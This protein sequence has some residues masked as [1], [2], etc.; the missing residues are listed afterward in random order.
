[1]VFLVFAAFLPLT[2]AA[3]EDQQ[4]ETPEPIGG[5]TFI[6]EV[7]F[8]VVNVDVFVR[9]KKGHPVTGLTVEDFR[10]FQDGDPRKVTNFA[11]FSEEVVAMRLA[12]APVEPTPGPTPGDHVDTDQD[13][14]ARAPEIKPVYI[15]LYIDNE[16]LRPFDRNRVLTQVRRF[17]REVMYPH[18]RVMVVSYQRSL[19]IIQPFTND[20][21][22]V[23]DAVK[24]VFKAVGG[25]TEYDNQRGR[26]LRDLGKLREKGAQRGGGNPTGQQLEM[27]ARIQTYADQIA[28]DLEFG[29][30]ALRQVTTS[31]SGL[32][33]R[34]F[35]VYVSSGLPMTPAK[36]L[37]NEFSQ[38]YEGASVLPMMMR[39]N[40]KRLYDNLT[41]T[42]NAQGVAFITI[43]ATG[44]GGTGYVSA[45]Y[46]TP[47]DPITATLYVAN[48]QETLGYMADRTGGR[49][50]LNAN[51][52]T[53][54]LEDFRN[55]LFTYYSLGYTIS[56]SGSDRVHRIEV[57]VPD[58]TEYQVSYRRSFVEKSLATRVQDTVV[59]GLMYEL[60]DNPMAIR[61]TT[62][63]AKP[64]T[65]SRWM[66]PLEVSVPLQSIALVQHGE[67]YVGQV[68]LFMAAR[69]D[70][71]KQSDLQ[72]REQEIR[73]PTDDID[74][75]RN[76]TIVI[77]M[78][79]LM[80]EGRYRLSIGVLDSFTRQ[81]S[82][83]TFRREVP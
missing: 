14:R 83:L 55:D 39:Y 64:A 35:L 51:D 78:D 48:H 19:D 15:V 27:L 33:G 23:Y 2:L 25:R 62:L 58:H 3:Q 45:E 49:A 28:N 37:F 26:L 81:S 80:E 50:I 59:S 67:E 38:I 4:P 54:G 56:A 42:A 20:D 77:Q 36:D 18:V 40:R 22:S 10:L 82:F 65:G 31:V 32:E 34:K 6:D 66:L 5:L 7:E 68:V 71:G 60:D 24:E 72:R 75:R 16:A 30:N 29:M 61:A 9:D 21:G 79:L 47:V 1:L 57:K 63:E 74:R 17:L 11:A 70:K 53:V 8:T 12:G 13:L 52:V 76:E 69:D 43:D 41:A 46:G 73:I 44:L